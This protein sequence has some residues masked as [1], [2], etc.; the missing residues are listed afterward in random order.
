MCT[1]TGRASKLGRRECSP[2]DGSVL[3]WPPKCSSFAGGGVGSLG[4][5]DAGL[6]DGALVV[7]DDVHRHL[8]PGVRP[9]GMVVEL[10]GGE[11]NLRHERERFGEVLE[12]EL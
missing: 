9:V 5:G 1:S 7:A 3:P 8:V 4:Q 12:R 6:G 10:L 2:Y 11:R